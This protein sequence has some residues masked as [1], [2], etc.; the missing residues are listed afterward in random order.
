[1]IDATI[2]WLNANSG[3]LTTLTSLA[4]LL[5]WLFYAQLLYSSYTRQTKPKLIINR[6]AGRDLDAY[7]MISNM[8]SEAIYL[9]S[10][11]G[12]VG[13]GERSYACDITDCAH[14]VRASEDEGATFQGPVE[15]GGYYLLTSFGKIIAFVLDASRRAADGVPPRRDEVDYIEIRVVSIYGNENRPVG[16]YRRFDLEATEAGTTLIPATFITRRL[17][18]RF[19]QKRIR[20]WLSDVKGF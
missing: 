18:R 13:V 4:T 7:C 12:V 1:M 16:V 10:V 3:A 14:H 19:H 9:S 6:S 17:S 15:S 20:R 2:D 11:I 5:V 8:S